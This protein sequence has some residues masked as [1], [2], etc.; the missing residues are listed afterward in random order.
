MSEKKIKPQWNKLEFLLRLLS[1][2]LGDFHS[3]YLSYVRA[4][5]KTKISIHS[6]ALT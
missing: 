3:G 5:A 2:S 1:T 4:V 6:R